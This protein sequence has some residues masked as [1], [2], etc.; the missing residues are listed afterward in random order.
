MPKSS[1]ARPLDE[2]KQSPADTACGSA[3]ALARAANECV[4]QH[5]R[6]SQ[7]LKAGCSDDELMHFAEL[8]T[9]TEKHLEAM[10][11]HYES[12]ATAAPEAKNEEWWHAANQLWLAS[13]E[14]TR[15]SSGATHAQRLAGKHSREK[16]TELTLEY[17]L[18]R[19]ALLALKQADQAYRA[20]RGTA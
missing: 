2:P 9:L 12:T 15:R 4:R 11:L 14:Y 8:A 7:S 20:L 3:D 18:E 6:L 16:L 5:E 1:T 13:R 19:S 10:T 17:E